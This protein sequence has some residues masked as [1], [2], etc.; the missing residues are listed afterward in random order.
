MLTA[1]TDFFRSC[2]P[3]DV[4]VPNQIRSDRCQKCWPHIRLTCTRIRPPYPSKINYVGECA[5]RWMGRYGPF[6]APCNGNVTGFSTLQAGKNRT[7]GNWICLM[8]VICLA[9]LVHI[10]GM[11]MVIWCLAQNCRWFGTESKRSHMK[12]RINCVPIISVE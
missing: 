11:W 5:V 4:S 12:M 9:K 3:A 10:D 8:N 2:I 7:H 1:R 6:I